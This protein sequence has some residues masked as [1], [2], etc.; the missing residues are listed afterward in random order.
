[1]EASDVDL[2]VRLRCDPIMTADLGGPRRAEDMPEKVARG[3]ADAASDTAWNLVIIPDALQLDVVAGSV[4]VYRSQA[5]RAEVGWMVLPGHQGRG[6]AK[7]AVL[8]LLEREQQEQRWGPF[9]A[10]TSTANAAS[11]GLCRSLP[12]RLVGEESYVFDGQNYTV[13]HWASD[14]TAP[15]SA[16]PPAE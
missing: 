2:Y 5:G 7:A 10:F 11:N 4:H 8:L 3:V 16:V 12:F 15:G 1:M 6:V 9:H 14:P 13:N